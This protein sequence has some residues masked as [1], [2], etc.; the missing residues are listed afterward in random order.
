MEMNHLD[1]LT[2]EAIIPVTTDEDLFCRF[3]TGNDSL[4]AMMPAVIENDVFPPVAEDLSFVSTD[5]V[6]DTLVSSPSNLDILELYSGYSEDK[7]YTAIKNDG[8]GFPTNSGGFIPSE[9]Y[10]YIAALVNPETALEDTVVYGMVYSEIPIFLESG[11]YRIVGSQLDLES[12]TAIGDIE[13]SVQ[14]S[15][16]ILACNFSD[17]TEDEY[18]GEWPSITNSL[19]LSFITNKF[20]LPM[21]FNVVDFTM[22]SLQFIDQLI[23]PS[24]DNT[25]PS[26]TDLNVIQGE[27]VTSI[28]L[29]YDDSDH[30]F[31]LVAEVIVDD[32]EHYDLIPTSFDFHES[33]EFQGTIMDG[34]WT[35]L[36]IRFSDNGY[37][38][39]TLE[40]PITGADDIF[41]QF[42]NKCT[43]FPNPFNPQ[44]SI[45]YESAIDDI[46]NVK[47]YN[48]RGQ[49]VRILADEL[50]VKLGT[51]IEFIWDGNDIHDEQV[52]SGI[53]YLEVK[54][55]DSTISKKMS[56]LK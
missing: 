33:V 22:P 37:D 18:F 9:F 49:I 17:F 43:I 4:T 41:P 27:G 56:L 53:Y 23:V 26:L 3:K 34:D 38:F 20:V 8:S 35:Q 28:S 19:G 46:I 51:T 24:F 15:L 44:T 13:T 25:L 21:A 11:L 47:I 42:N 40:Y 29:M 31:P 6:G 14:D 55:A 45:S 7:F 30:N 52:S 48:C 10:I 39:V 32:T 1:G 36:V 54:G 2:Y 50:S 5:A 16:L 12:F